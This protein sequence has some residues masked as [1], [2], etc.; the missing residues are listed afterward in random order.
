MAQTDPA[1][2]VVIPVYNCERYLA[3][4]I[5]SVIAQGKDLTQIVVVDDG[6]TDGSARVAKDFGEPVHYIFQEHAGVAAA[7][8]R[9]IEAIDSPFLA[10]LDAD[11]LWTA[12]RLERMLA[13]FS[14]DPQ[15]EMIFGRTEEFICPLLGEDESKKLRCMASPMSGY[16]AGAML[17]R[18]ASFLRAGLFDTTLR[19]G[20]FIAWFIQAQKSALRFSSID[21]LVLRRRLHAANLMRQSREA[22][23]DYLRIIKDKMAFERERDG[24]VQGESDLRECKCRR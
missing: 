24:V 10:F 8:N 12:G 23:G 6:S 17:A 5:E 13:E 7:R 20:E 16:L 9:G 3:Q 14:R 11:D 19:I 18:R 22:Y 1:V 21:D 15:L 2:G 4:A